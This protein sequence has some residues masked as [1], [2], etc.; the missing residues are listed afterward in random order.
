MVY[1]RDFSRLM[2]KRTLGA[3]LVELNSKKQQLVKILVES[4][5]TPSEYIHTNTNTDNNTSFSLNMSS[6]CY[7]KHFDVVRNWSQL[8]EVAKILEAIDELHNRQ[9]L[10]L[11]NLLSSK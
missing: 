3:A 11:E 7:D 9:R 1:K 5:R 10:C 6:K 8:R 4:V 2:S